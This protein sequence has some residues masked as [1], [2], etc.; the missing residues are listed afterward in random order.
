MTTVEG[1]M[2]RNKLTQDLF[3]IKNI[4]DAK[5]VMLED[6]KGYV[7]IWLHKKDLGI[8]FEEVKE[9]SLN[10]HYGRGHTQA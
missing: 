4:D 6:E 10:G 7:R 2:L 5:V 9:V 8:F 1:E 3:K